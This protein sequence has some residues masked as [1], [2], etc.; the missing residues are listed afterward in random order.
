LIQK[1]GARPRGHCDMR[2]SW[3]TDHRL[4][5]KQSICADHMY[6]MICAESAVD[7]FGLGLT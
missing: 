4:S 2:P 3:I 1:P 7:H 6:S 5:K